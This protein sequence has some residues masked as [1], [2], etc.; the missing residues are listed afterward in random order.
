MRSGQ[1][2]RHRGKGEAMNL[3]NAAKGAAIFALLGSAPLPAGAMEIVGGSSAAGYG[4]NGFVQE[5]VVVRGPHGGA[6]AGRPGGVH[7]YRPGYRPGYHG[8]VGHPG[9]RPVYPG[10]RPAMR[11]GPVRAGITGAP[12]AP[13]RR[14]RRSA[15]SGRPQPPHGRRRRP[16]RV[17]AGTTPIQASRAVSGT[18]ARNAKCSADGAR[19]T[20]TR[21][22]RSNGRPF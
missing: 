4:A 16:R 6:Y 7:A 11:A 18:P 15:S 17:S 19:T 20:Q 3:S 13:L 1:K 2:L 5:V 14:A 9:Y 22:R 21:A 10:Y 8:Y 12:A